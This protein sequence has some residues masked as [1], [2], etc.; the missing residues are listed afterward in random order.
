MKEV[1]DADAAQCQRE[2]FALV[3]FLMRPLVLLLLAVQ[4]VFSGSSKQ[5][6]EPYSSPGKKKSKCAAS[7]TA[8]DLQK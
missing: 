6:A 2:V 5:T 3:A 4:N 7:H 8:S 1:G